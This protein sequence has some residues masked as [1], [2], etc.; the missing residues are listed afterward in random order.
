MKLVIITGE[1]SGDVLGA[2]RMD[3]LKKSY[4]KPIELYGIG[5]K[6][7]EKH[8][9]IYLITLLP[10]TKNVAM[11]LGIKTII[12]KFY[13][14]KFVST[15]PKPLTTIEYFQLTQCK[16]QI[17]GIQ[18]CQWEWQKLLLLYGRIT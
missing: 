9:R 4:L 3:A 10:I 5:G 7:L 16:E 17:R 14:H 2:S 15:T 13:P 11:N 8:N 6:E 1:E 12:F 18:E